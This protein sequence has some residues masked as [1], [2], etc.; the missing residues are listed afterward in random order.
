MKNKRL[1]IILIVFVCLGTVAIL[2]GVVFTVKTIDISFLGKPDY[3]S[4]TEKAKLEDDIRETISFMYN[5]NIL[6]Q[7]DQK[8]IK[9]SIEDNDNFFRIRIMN[10]EAHFPNRIEIRIRER[11][12]VFKYT[13]DAAKTFVLDGQL[14]IIDNKIPTQENGNERSLVDITEQIPTENLQEAV[15]GSYLKDYLPE[16][17]NDAKERYDIL[18][19]LMP[20][21]AKNYSNED[22]VSELFLSA[23]FFTEYSGSDSDFVF[24]LTQR[25][26][27]PH[28]EPERNFFVI[29]I[30]DAKIRFGD[31]LELVWYA[32]EEIGRV[33]VYQ[34]EGDENGLRGSFDNNVQT[35]E[36]T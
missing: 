33:G 31:K 14:R 35:W 25:V 16:S 3:F 17:N 13:V 7:F 9:S 28:T 2:G 11:Y 34:I 1:L 29:E 5:K 6:F 21:F 18:F 12:P 27:N 36:W 10:I 32:R 20:F 24:V 26:N 22:A 8:K 15:I 23:E 30:W 19:A 4:G